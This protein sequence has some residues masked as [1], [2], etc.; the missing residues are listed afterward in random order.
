MREWTY[1][2]TA[3]VGVAALAPALLVALFAPELLL[4]VGIAGFAL[5]AY[6]IYRGSHPT[7][8]HGDPWVDVVEVVTLFFALV[9]GLGCVVASFL[10]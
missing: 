4:F 8:I 6:V 1:L 9:V 5:A 10:V 7:D 3:I 2:V